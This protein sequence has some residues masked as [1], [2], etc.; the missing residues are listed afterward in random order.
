MTVR[1][2]TNGC[3]LAAL[4]EAVVAPSRVEGHP[5]RKRDR[6]ATDPASANAYRW[7]TLVLGRP[8]GAEILR[9]T[10]THVALVAAI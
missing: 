7:I 1:I 5:K 9:R 3:E 6:L 8:G 10:L 2:E 4:L